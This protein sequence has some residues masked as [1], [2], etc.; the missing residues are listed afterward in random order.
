M[1]LRGF[2]PSQLPGELGPGACRAAGALG[3]AGALQSGRRIAPGTAGVC[4]PPRFVPG[5][6]GPR[7]TSQQPASPRKMAFGEIGGGNQVPRPGS[8]PRKGRL[9]SGTSHPV[10]SDWNT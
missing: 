6:E 2:S 4:P 9:F 5:L 10:F 7:V 8:F 3:D 1:G